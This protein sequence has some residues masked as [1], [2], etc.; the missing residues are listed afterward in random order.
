MAANILIMVGP[1]ALSMNAENAVLGR[2]S[3]LFFP[4]EMWRLQGAGSIGG[5]PRGARPA[6][7]SGK[8]RMGLTRRIGAGFGTDTRSARQFSPVH[9][10][11]A[12][13]A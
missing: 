6:S 12:H 9:V 13:G 10:C 4:L 7:R 1:F 5:S 11:C 3:I 8:I 2:T